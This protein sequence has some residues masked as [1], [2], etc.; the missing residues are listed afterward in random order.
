VLAASEATPV[1]N[2]A[3]VI[4]GWGRAEAR[5]AIDGANIPRGMSFRYGFR[6][7]PTASDLIVWIERE[8]EKP[9]VLVIEPVSAGKE[10]VR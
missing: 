1:R 5:L 2:V 10:G 6:K 9:I 7:T 3:L 4:H 8:A